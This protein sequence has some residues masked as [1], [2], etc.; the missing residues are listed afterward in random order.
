MLDPVPHALRDRME[1]L[2][3]PG[4]TEEEKLQIVQRHLLPKQ[5]IENGL[6]DQKIEFSEDALREI[7]HSYTR[8]AGLGHLDREIPRVGR[9]Q[10]RSI[11][12]GETA[13]PARTGDYE[14]KY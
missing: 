7:I 11:T 6:G 3:L 8:E 10:A 4:Y 12:D 1:V 13:P 14:K 2:E 9:R 5:L